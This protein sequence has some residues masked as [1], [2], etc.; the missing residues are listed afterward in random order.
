MFI[1]ITPIKEI[2]C[3][4]FYIKAKES[5]HIAYS[6]LLVSKI[7]AI[8]SIT[9]CAPGHCD[10]SVYFQNDPLNVVVRR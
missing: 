3:R 4:C 5:K 2:F 1:I 10:V 6:L 7:E 8:N 9:M